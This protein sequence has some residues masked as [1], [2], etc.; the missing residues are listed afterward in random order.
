MFELAEDLPAQRLRP[1]RR[2]QKARAAL[3]ATILASLAS[4]VAGFFAGCSTQ[5]CSDLKGGGSA[6]SSLVCGGE[7]SPAPEPA[8]VT[9]SLCQPRQV[10][11]Q[12]F[13]LLDD[14]G[15]P[16][17]GL[18]QVVKVLAVPTCF[19]PRDRACTQD[20]QCAI[21]ACTSGLCPCTAS[22]NPL[23]DILQ[24]AF[25]GIA[26][27]SLDPAE[28]G[29]MGG[30]CVSAAL[31]AA[32]PVAQRNRL[33]EL[34]R[35]LDVLLLQGGGK[36]LLSD[37]N[38]QATVLALLHYIEGKP[39]HTPHY[40]LFTGLGR[41][42]QN[43][44]LCKPHQ[45]YR[46]LDQGLAYLTPQNAAQLF[47]SVQTLLDDPYTQTFFAQLA[48]GQG[49]SGRD[50]IIVLVNGLQPALLAAQ[51]GPALLAVVNDQLLQPFVYNP[52]N[53][54]PQSFKDEVKAIMDS[55]GLL[56]GD[57]AGIF[58]PL[59]AVLACVGDPLI[60]CT[61]AKAC[62]DHDNELVGALYDLLSRPKAQD[63]LDLAT[64]LGAVNTLLSLDTTGQTART[65]RLVMS[66]IDQSEEAT[67]GV[68]QLLAQVLTADLGEKLLPALDTMV[69]NKVLGEFL[70]LLDDLL[71]SCS[72]PTP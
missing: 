21:G 33:C 37:P 22:F 51:S 20:S 70:S 68:R 47:A 66:S 27:I 44:G 49:A 72:P 3:W 9:S 16:L 30:K 29:A 64:L 36:Q 45:T 50:A 38:V 17:D 41:M 61:D 58:A 5:Q 52:N 54:I 28:P 62:T 34:R 63:G 12:F 46:L 71:Y 31:A 14:P 19:A 6:F 15:K 40:D 26:T 60:R 35:S 7:G 8:K 65:L 39:D 11:P 48:T 43:P 2:W 24:L 4:A 23:A 57:Q 67:D 25:R 42:A 10:M 53:S 18:R 13:K 32:L 59:Q 1:L 69:E 55:A 56:L